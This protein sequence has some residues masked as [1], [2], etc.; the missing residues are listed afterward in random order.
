MNLKRN[1]VYL[2]VARQLR[3]A[4]PTTREEY[5]ATKRTEVYERL[6]RHLLRVTTKMSTPKAQLQGRRRTFASLIRWIIGWVKTCFQ[7]NLSRFLP[8]QFGSVS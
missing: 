8:E 6:L 2:H 4:N 7:T 1:L 3:C 5:K